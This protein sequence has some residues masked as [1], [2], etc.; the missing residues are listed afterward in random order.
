APAGLVQPRER[1]AQ[2][3]CRVAVLVGRVGIG[4]RIADIAKPGGPEQGVGQ[5]VQH[6]VG[7]AMPDEAAGVLDPHAAENQRSARR[8][9][10]RVVT[11]AY[12]HDTSL[13]VGRIAN[14]SYTAWDGL[15]IRPNAQRCADCSG[16]RGIVATR[17]GQ[18]LTPAGMASTA[19]FSKRMN[20]LM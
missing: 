9:P 2:E 12:A 18:K 6:D 11:Q 19:K 13:T 1:F 10:V 20:C 7:V 17:D 16:A 15:P 3:K 14:P 8:Q 4:I 5:G